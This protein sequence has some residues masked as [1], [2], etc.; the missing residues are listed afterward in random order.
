M[1]RNF[2]NTSTNNWANSTTENWGVTYEDPFIFNL[3][4]EDYDLVLM[5]IYEE[6]YTFATREANLFEE[7]YTLLFTPTSYFTEPYVDLLRALFNEP[8]VDTPIPLKEFN[9]YY[10]D[11]YL[12]LNDLSLLYGNVLPPVRLF[13]LFYEMTPALIKPIIE[14]YVDATLVTTDV[15]LLYNIQTNLSNVFQEIYAIT[16]FAVNN[17]FNLD[18]DLEVNNKILT[19]FDET[20]NLL[21]GVTQYV[22]QG[23][24]ILIN[25]R[26]IDFLSFDLEQSVNSYVISG[27][28]QLLN[29]D[30]YIF[31]KTLDDV[32]CTIDGTDYNLFIETKQNNITNDDQTYTL[33][34]LSPTVK[35]DAPYSSTIVK[36]FPSGI[37]AQA[38]VQQMADYQGIS[39]D[40]QLLD[41]TIPSHAISINGETPIEVIRKVVHA[42]GGIV[43]TKPNGDLLLISQYPVSVPNWATATPVASFSLDID[44][45]SIGESLNIVNGYN[46]YNITDQGYSSADIRLVDE[47]VDSQTKIIKGYRI[48]FDDGEFDLETSGGFDISIFKDINPIEEQ[49]PLA[50]DEWEIVEFIEYTGTTSLPIYEV[51]DYEWLQEDLGAFQIS[52]EGTLTCINQTQDP[53]E[54]LLKIKYKTKYWKWVVTC[55]D[56]R[57]V[58]FYVPEIEE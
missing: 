44:L 10:N 13:E 26:Y 19:T 40:Y 8:Y 11:M 42:V 57:H 27:S 58:Q 32:V 55:P 31:C 50:T 9:E 7:D 51:V 37:T 22:N 28:I 46:A 38:L 20:F 36:S 18:Y 41:W 34:I 1:I 48:P 5:L 45:I 25:S 33:N 53:S 15:D 3:Y 47:I 24:S 14:P 21:D 4:E 52:E 35:L 16:E 49:I 12:P 43:Q 6:V 30:D 56:V 39:I 54:S 2:K 17:L 23:V 29:E